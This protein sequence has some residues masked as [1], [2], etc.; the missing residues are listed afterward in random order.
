[1]KLLIVLDFFFNDH[2]ISVY[3]LTTIVSIRTNSAVEITSGIR[4]RLRS[5]FSITGQAL[6]NPLNVCPRI[7][8]LLPSFSYNLVLSNSTI[9]KWSDWRLLNNEI[10]F[11]N[12]SLSLRL[13][14]AVWIASIHV[15]TN[16]IVNS[17]SPLKDTSDVI[18]LLVVDPVNFIKAETVF[19]VN[20]HHF[21]LLI[22]S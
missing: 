6:L 7:F 21:S 15:E 14:G 10:A 8:S 12:L 2:H 9:R 4:L 1:M 16:R 18:V 13:I 22:R 3:R 20:T 17:T 11:S 5:S 19:I